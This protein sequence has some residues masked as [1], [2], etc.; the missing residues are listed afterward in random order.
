MKCGCR[1][2]QHYDRVA[3]DRRQSEGWAWTHG[4]YTLGIF[5]FDQENMQWSV[6]AVDRDRTAERA[7]RFGGVAMIDGEPSD[8]GRIRAGAN[9]APGGHALPDRRRRLPRG[10][11]RL[12]PLLG[13][14]RLPVPQG[15]QSARPLGTTLRHGGRVGRPAPPLYQGHRGKGGRKRAW[16]T[17]AR[18]CTSIPAGTPASPP[19][20][21]ANSGSGRGRPSWRKCSRNTA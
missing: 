5:K 15:F 11:V 20:F 1:A 8:L 18:P 4:A 2:D 9:G 3:A 13:R 19:S 12:P 10:D 14:E 6:L 16:P 17:V 7:S 21:G